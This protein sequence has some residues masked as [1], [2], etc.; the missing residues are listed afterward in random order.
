MPR[1][2][3]RA[4]TIQDATGAHAFTPSIPDYLAVVNELGREGWEVYALERGVIHMKRQIED[5]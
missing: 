3:Y 1:F 4:E 2:E 5:R